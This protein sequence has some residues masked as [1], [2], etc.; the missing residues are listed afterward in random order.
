MKKLVD[1]RPNRVHITRPSLWSRSSGTDFWANPAVGFAGIAAD[2]LLTDYGWTLTSITLTAGSLA[3]LL[4]SADVG[5]PNIAALDAGSD[6]LLGPSIFG[7]YGHGL[8]AGQF[9]GYMP[10]KLCFE[11]YANF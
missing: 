8:A 6:L 10:T 5:T 2:E 4:S 11:S 9:L 1:Q 3:D 7:D